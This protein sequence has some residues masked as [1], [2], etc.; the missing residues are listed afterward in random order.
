MRARFNIA[1]LPACFR[2]RAV[3]PPLRRAIRCCADSRAAE[4]VAAGRVGRRSTSFLEDKHDKLFL[5]A[6]TYMMAASRKFHYRR[7]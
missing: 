3:M 2:G 4:D 6:Q 1:F 7:Q 5:A